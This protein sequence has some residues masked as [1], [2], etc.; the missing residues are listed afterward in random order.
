MRT[1]KTAFLSILL[2][3]LISPVVS[4]AA[5]AVDV[6]VGKE[7]ILKLKTL[8]KRVSVANP[9]IVALT[10]ISPSE[11]LLNGKK[12][13]TTSL[14]VWDAEGKTSFFDVRVIG[15]RSQ[16]EGQI[17]DLS[18]QD[19][20]TVEFVKDTVVLSGNAKN[21]QT[22]N[23]AVEIAQA[24]APK[25]I[26]HVII[27]EAQ[28][29]LLE[30]KVAQVN[31]SK[32]KELGIGFLTKQKNFELTAPGLIGVPQGGIGSGSTTTT[33]TE[34]TTTTSSTQARIEPGIEKFLLRDIL[35]QIAVAHYP[36][37]IG[38]MLRALAS[39]GYAKVLAEPNLIVRSGEKGNFLAGERVPIQTVSATGTPSVS[40]ELVGV[41][42]NFAPDVLE[43]GVI[44]LKIDPA[45]VSAV[46]GFVQFSG[47]ISA[48]R[49]ESRQVTTSVDLKD[50][51]SLVLAGLLSEDMIK[52]MKK[53]PILGDIPIL[54]LLF[55]STS[56]ELREKELAFFITPR[57]VKP[58][59]PGVKTELP[60]DKKLTPEE[61][62]EFKWIP[63]PE[64][65]E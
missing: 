31:K 58:N 13:G 27:P 65:S 49:I 47:G 60:T 61:E 39:K 5:V 37:D 33:G 8:S 35:P 48:P 62:R 20:I 57:L 17:K 12:T 19:E 29:V 32:F 50:G 38:V 3:I 14:I 18:P 4:S 30:V 64:K 9:E 36:S 23:K 21:Q 25:V 7:T 15:E 28:Q 16:L 53:I 2:I 56:D 52:N 41:K 24:Y 51:E 46:T 34:G 11:I 59:A 54:G 43:T 63:L 10:L 26:N 45:E 55:R 44:R 6:T 1:T 22:I 42:L 40:Y